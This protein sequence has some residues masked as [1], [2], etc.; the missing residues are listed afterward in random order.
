MDGVLRAF[1]VETGAELWARPPA[2]R[3]QRER[4]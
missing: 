1:D 2:R 3:R 4:R